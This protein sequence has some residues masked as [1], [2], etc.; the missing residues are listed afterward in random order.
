MTP[1]QM[2]S[3]FVFRQF[4]LEALAAFQNEA[5]LTF[6]DDHILDQRNIYSSFCLSA[7]NH[8][9]L[10]NDLNNQSRTC[11]GMHHLRA[12]L[13]CSECSPVFTESFCTTFPRLHDTCGDCESADATNLPVLPYIIITH[14]AIVEETG[15]IDHPS[16]LTRRFAPP[17]RLPFAQWTAT[18]KSLLRK[19]SATLI[20]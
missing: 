15:L 14:T 2:S 13:G 11:F 18:M 19:S 9:Q 5:V 1:S 17:C 10:L 3:L 12:W 7:K 20:V 8:M 6:Y 16:S 4:H